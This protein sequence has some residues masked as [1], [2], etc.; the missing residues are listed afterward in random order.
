MKKLIEAIN[1]DLQEAKDSVDLDL[2]NIDKKFLKSIEK[3]YGVVKSK[4]NA[5]GPSG[6]P[7]V[8]FTG[9]SNKL[10]NLESDYLDGK[11]IFENIEIEITIE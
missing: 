9:D 2:M 10:A 1:A 4:I 8:F 3:K 11:G 5:K 6:W 7:Q